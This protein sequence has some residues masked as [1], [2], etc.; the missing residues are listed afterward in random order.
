MSRPFY[1]IFIATL[2]LG[3]TKEEHGVICNYEGI[4]EKSVQVFKADIKPSTVYTLVTENLQGTPHCTFHHGSSSIVSIEEDYM[5]Y[6]FKSH[7]DSERTEAYLKAIPGEYYRFILYL[8][9]KY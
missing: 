7:P 4:S 3:C 9:K 8:G 6:T 5:V 2:L 1:I